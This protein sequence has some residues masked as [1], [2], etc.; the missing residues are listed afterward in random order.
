[1]AR[2]LSRASLLVFAWASISG[3]GGSYSGTSP[4]SVERD[5]ARPT[6]VS[7]NPCTDAILAEV[8]GPGQLLAIS[9]YSRDPANSS[10]DLAKARRYRGVSGS[11]EEVS[12]LGPK[13][14]VASSFLSPATANAFREQGFEV[15]T[16][17]IATDLQ[18]ARG[19]IRQLAK[20]SG[21]P[22]LGRRLIARINDA[23]ARAAPPPGT[24]PVPALVWESAGL[25]AGD[26]TLIV[27]MM[28]HSGF[29]NAAS[30]RGLSQADFLPLEEVLADPPQV[31]FAVGDPFAEEDR[32][33][34]HPALAS[35]TG[36]RRFALDHSLLW[37][38]GPTI[39]RALDRLAQVRRVLTRS[40]SRVRAQSRAKPQLRAR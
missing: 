5:P 36:T 10:M 19:Q 8:T 21:H 16:V 37:C 18:A 22:E 30:A 7:L 9:N 6:I 26:D 11:V 15:V 31:I 28:E 25:V 4:A 40:Q 20:L 35:L 39:P 27:D 1:M 38:G 32:M 33:L 3:C 14:V 17:P 34:H 13:V 12:A 2:G 24:A 23:V 29:T